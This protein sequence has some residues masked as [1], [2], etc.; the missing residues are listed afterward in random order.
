MA[1][2][3]SKKSQAL[4]AMPLVNG[5]A[6]VIGQGVE[7][8]VILPEIGPFITERPE[9][10]YL[11]APTPSA[12]F[13]SAYSEDAPVSKSASAFDA[14]LVKRGELTEQSILSFAKNKQGKA[15]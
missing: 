8:F 15:R 6:P 13:A 9:G 2:V 12:R 7:Q 3:G 1:L 5:P 11:R 10:N 14:V 4:Q